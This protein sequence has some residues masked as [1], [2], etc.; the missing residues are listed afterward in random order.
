MSQVRYTAET[1]PQ[2]GEELRQALRQALND[3]T[4]L[5]DLIQLIR[6]LA[7]YEIRYSMNSGD[8]LARFEAG[9]LGDEIDFIRWANKVEIYQETKSELN[10]MVELVEAY[11]VPVMA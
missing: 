5:D 6:D 1:I 4:P 11:A 7:Q 8:F 3:T 2:S 9:E 10:Q